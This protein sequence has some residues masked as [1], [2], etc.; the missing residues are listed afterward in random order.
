MPSSLKQ[1]VTTSVGETLSTDASSDTVMNS[2]T[3]T[4]V[5]SRSR[6][7]IRR[8]SASSR[9]LGSS[10]RRRDLRGD[11]PLMLASVRL[12]L[13][14][15]ASLSTDE[16]RPPLRRRFLSRRR[17]SAISPGAAEATGRGPTLAG[18]LRGGRGGRSTRMGRCTLRGG[19]GAGAGAGTTTSAVG[20]STGA[21][22][23]GGSGATSTRASGS[24]TASL[25]SAAARSSIDG[26]S[27]AAASSAAAAAS[28]SRSASAATRAAS[29]SA[30]FAATSAAVRRRR[31]G[32][33]S[34]SALAAGSAAL[35][36]RVLV[37][38]G[39]AVF[40]RFSRS[41]RVRARATW[42]SS[43]PDRWLRT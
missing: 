41:Q 29:C 38:V 25:K 20:T 43:S 31:T 33:W 39:A 18:R 13:A 7:S 10:S 32:R 4:S 12:M 30:S 40:L 9:A 37:L 26:F 16:R 34:F 3:R 21:S 17:S 15:T 5:F 6:S 11:D 28:A 35:R 23:S 24:G 1:K 42:A 2:F 19:V 36:R 22:T 8:I 27:A 14:C